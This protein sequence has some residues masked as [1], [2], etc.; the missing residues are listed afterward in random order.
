MFPAQ[1]NC[2]TILQLVAAGED[3]QKDKHDLESVTSLPKT[4]LLMNLL[5][6]SVM[7][8]ALEEVRNRTF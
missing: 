5:H 4:V 7:C 3:N 2:V 8:T 1:M 6:H